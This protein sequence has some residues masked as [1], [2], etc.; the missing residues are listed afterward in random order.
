V[1]DL[2]KLLKSRGMGGNASKEQ[3]FWRWFLAHEAELDNSEKDQER[4]FDQ[5]AAQFAKV[6]REL[7]FEF[8][9]RMM[10]EGR[11]MREF[12]ISAGG[13]KSSFPAVVSLANAAPPLEKFYVTAFRPRRPPVNGLECGGVSVRPEQVQVSLLSDGKM[14]GLHLFF[15]TSVKEDGA[16]K[17]IGY[18][19]LDEVLGEF[20][21]EMKVG[22]IEMYSIDEPVEFE[23]MPLAELPAAFDRLVAKLEGR[24][25]RPS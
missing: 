8:G 3:L 19:L 13:I 7:C 6:D 4:V 20:D 5:L 11:E 9:P 10:R 2:S 1:F 25:L 18:L 21:V 12:V 17:M 24:S 15:P 23:R 22:M 16:R 14:A